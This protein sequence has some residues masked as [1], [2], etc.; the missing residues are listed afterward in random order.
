MPKRI[1]KSKRKVLRLA[2]EEENSLECV[3]TDENSRLE[4]AKEEPSPRL[5]PKLN[6]IT[7]SAEIVEQL[8]AFSD[9]PKQRGNLTTGPERTPL[10]VMTSEQFEAY[11]RQR[12]EEVRRAVGAR[13]AGS[14]AGKYTEFES[15]DALKSHL[16]TLRATEQPGLLEV[17]LTAPRGEPLELPR[18]GPDS[19]AL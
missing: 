19:N 4:Q 12:L 10:G 7:S 14:A 15:A 5:F 13:L 1:S 6:V 8:L 18:D 17:L 16:A 11:K 9:P 3:T 2:L